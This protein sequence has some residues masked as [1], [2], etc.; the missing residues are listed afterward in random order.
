MNTET[1]QDKTKNVWSSRKPN[2]KLTGSSYFHSIRSFCT[3]L[4][5]LQVL[6]YSNQLNTLPGSQ[7][8]AEISAVS[9]VL[10]SGHYPW[11]A[12]QNYA[13]VGAGNGKCKK[14]QCITVLSCWSFAIS[15]PEREVYETASKNA[16]TARKNKDKLSQ[17]LFLQ[18]TEIHSNEAS[19]ILPVIKLWRYY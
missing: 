16:P 10:E 1:S 19:L 17:L 13:W 7:L 6:L 14:V 4:C 12:A 8:G 15:M 3:G 2:H 18:T 5:L 9:V 11:K